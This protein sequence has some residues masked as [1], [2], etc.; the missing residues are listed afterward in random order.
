[1]IAF[2]TRWS[3]FSRERRFGQANRPRNSRVGDEIGK[4]A[5]DLVDHLEGK[6]V[7]TIFHRQNYG[8]DLK[9]LIEM[10]SDRLDGREQLRET[11]ERVVL[12]LDGDND[13]V[14]RG[15]RVDR[16]QSEGRR[17]VHEHGVVV[18]RRAKSLP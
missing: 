8:E 18:P 16:Q 17:A 3:R 11:L 12:A 5:S 1:M 2:S 15:E 14:A 7:S 4:M 10:H 9:A 6:P 13:D